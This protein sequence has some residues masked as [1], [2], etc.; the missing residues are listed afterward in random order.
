MMGPS[1]AGCL[2]EHEVF[3][4]AQ[5]RVATESVSRIEQHLDQCDACFRLVVA[6][7]RAP[8]PSFA[9]LSRGPGFAASITLGGDDHDAPPPER[10]RRG[11]PRIPAEL[12]GYRITATLGRG[13]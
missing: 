2:D 4:F 1:M 3:E 7:S 11:E 9:A 8:G 12:G 5:G 10:V 6:V 13:G